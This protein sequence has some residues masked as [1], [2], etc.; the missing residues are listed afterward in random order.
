[1]MTLFLLLVIAVIVFNE[2]KREK[3]SFDI[4]EQEPEE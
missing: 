3:N 4:F 1:M 2:Y